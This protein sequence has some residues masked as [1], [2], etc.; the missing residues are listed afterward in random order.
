MRKSGKKKGKA[1]F[2]VNFKTNAVLLAR[3]SGNIT[4]TSKKVGVSRPTLR[5]WIAEFENSM[6]ADPK[7]SDAAVRAI[8]DASAIRQKFLCEH[9][10]SLTTVIRKAISRADELIP[11]ADNLGSIVNAI[12]RLANV[13]KEFTPADEANPTSTT[14]N[15]LQQTIESRK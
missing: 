13:I 8:E 3:E 6:A 7:V 5:T 9:Y 1:E 15:L 10:D 14:I 11:K 2:S 12:E 4:E